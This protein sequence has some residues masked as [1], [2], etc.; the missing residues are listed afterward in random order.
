[1][2]PYVV[3]GTTKF[4]M[5]DIITSLPIDD[6]GKTRFSLTIRKGYGSVHKPYTCAENP[7]ISDIVNTINNSSTLY[8]YIYA[9]IIDGYVS[10]KLITPLWYASADEIKHKGLCVI[11]NPDPGIHTLCSVLGI[12]AF[13]NF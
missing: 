13:T 7:T 8:E 10:L 1:M 3:V 11:D 6:E 5:T 2:D 9:S 4:S 12:T